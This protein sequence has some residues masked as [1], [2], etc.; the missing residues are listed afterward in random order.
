MKHTVINR[1]LFIAAGLCVACVAAQE[2]V[3][4]IT[5]YIL[6]NLAAFQ[7]RSQEPFRVELE[8]IP[9]VCVETCY[10]LNPLCE[11]PCCI[12]LHVTR[13]ADTTDPTSLAARLLAIAQHKF[14]ERVAHKQKGIE[15]I[16]AL[17]NKRKVHPQAHAAEEVIDLDTYTTLKHVIKPDGGLFIFETKFDSPLLAFYHEEYKKRYEQEV[18]QTDDETSM[19]SYDPDNSEWSMFSTSISSGYSFLTDSE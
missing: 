1:I 17:L 14:P 16:R 4:G 13:H 3:D 6:H 15:K 10:A 5:R 18:P 19:L 9:E 11:H 7:H 8:N 12:S 2:S